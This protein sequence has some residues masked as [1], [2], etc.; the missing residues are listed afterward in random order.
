MPSTLDRLSS[1]FFQIV[2]Q[3]LES[4]LVMY[5][6]YDDQ[7]ALHAE[8][9]IGKAESLIDHDA[10]DV[11]AFESAP[12]DEQTGV[13]GWKFERHLLSRDRENAQNYG[14]TRA[15]GLATFREC[16]PAACPARSRHDST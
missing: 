14:C 4:I 13:G 7:V 12:S 16:P 5:R 8:L 3:R 11:R 9:L 6:T 15:A 2:D 10:L 1:C